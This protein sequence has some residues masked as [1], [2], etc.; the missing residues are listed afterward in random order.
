[1]QSV[2]H[3]LSRRLFKPLAFSLALLSVL[4]LIQIVPHAHAKHQD[5]AACR[6]CQVGHLGVT[7]AVSAISLS[8]PF[9]N[10]GQVAPIA[11][12]ISSQNFITHSP[13]RAP[14]TDFVS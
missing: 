13:S 1:M 12:L 2:A 10:F 14:P 8:V 5:E 4:F 6:I 11:I 3:S 9:V 7:P